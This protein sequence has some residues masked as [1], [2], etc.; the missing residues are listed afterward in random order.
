MPRRVLIA[1]DIFQDEIEHILAAR[2]ELQV[3]IVWLRAGLHNNIKLLNQTLRE[4]V[5]DLAE[6]PNDRL[7]LMIG[8]GCLPDMP[9]L[10]AAWGIPL[11]PTRNCLTAM[12]GQERLSF[13]EQNKNIV[14]TV[15]WIRKM[16]VNLPEISGEGGWNKDDLRMNYGRY[17][18]II[19]LDTGLNSLS[20][21][22]YLE[23]FDLVGVPLQPMACSPD[24]FQ[25]LFLDFLA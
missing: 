21:E 7:R 25:K 13:L 4:A 18:G 12:I 20:D 11:L 8:R 5:T 16:M 24:D 15:A 9:A 17:D 14:I 2:P 19:V 3:D 10:A 1:C 6:Q 22:E 23:V